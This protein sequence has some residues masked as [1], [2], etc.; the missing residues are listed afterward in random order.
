MAS[1]DSREGS[2]APLGATW[3]ASEEAHN[4]ALYSQ[5]ASRVTLLLYTPGDIV[6]PAFTYEF[7]PLQNKTGPVWHARIAKSQI[8]SARYYAYSV[9]GPAVPGASFEAAG[10]NPNKVLLDPYARAVFFPP[11][12]DRTAA[13]RTGSNAGKAPL[14]VLWHEEPF[15][16]SHDQHPRHDSDLVIYEMHVRGFT[17]NPKSGVS[18]ER[19]GTFLG[20]AEKIPYL[21][22]LGVTA[23]ELMPVFQFDDTEPNY[24]GYMPLNFFSPHHRYATGHEACQQIREFKQMVKAL[25]LAGI[26]VIL[27]VVYNHTGEGD[28]S[29]PT[30]SFRDIDNGAYYIA[31]SDPARLYADFTGTGN[32]LDCADRAVRQLI[33]DSLRY[34]V[35]E[36]HVDGFRF[37]LASV[38]SRNR[39]GSIN[40]GDPPIFGDIASDPDLAGVRMI[41]EPWEGNS[42]YPNYD[43]GFETVA[44]HA[45]S[46]CQ[47]ASCSCPPTPVI[48]Q[49]S[50]PGVGWRQWNDKFRNTVRGFVKSDSGLVGDLMTRV[51]GSADVF[52]DSLHEAYRPYQSLNYVSSHDGLTLY[53]LVAYNSPDSWNC[54]DRD[55]DEAVSNEVMSLRRRQAKNFVCL[56]MLSNGTPMFRAGDEFLQTQRGNGN[57]YNIDSPLT[58]LDWDRLQRHA[59][60]FRFCKK[61]V[62]FRK[63]HPSLV[64][65]QFWQ[66]DISWY[67][68]GHDVDWTYDSHALAYYLHGASQSDDDLYVMINAYWEPLE[69]ALQ[70][71]APQ[72]WRRVIDTA[73]KS[74][75]DFLESGR[76]LPTGERA[77]VVQDRSVA[78]FVRPQRLQ[79]S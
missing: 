54:G 65:S 30:F 15:D 9:N 21:K 48:L 62:A 23:V 7:D 64:R 39:D 45:K 19:R 79:S 43:L 37:D 32:T 56:L 66:D 49:R 63:L 44:T 35:R 25:H 36:M 34:W 33:V 22:E 55:G 71:G 10:F 4:F 50:F 28:E 27:D 31:S 42:Q 24:W 52:P 11:S 76:R 59:D 2:S 70:E 40:F 8:A 41:A 61:V 6:N 14:G 75:D 3:I 1:W 77:Y 73:R 58:W 20:I 51:Y 57:P 46:C 53:D 74:P 18:P 12:F 5:N 67:G 26:E 69:F 68:A 78:V 72:D 60:F 29:G 38:F 13:L 17:M 47:K 16:W